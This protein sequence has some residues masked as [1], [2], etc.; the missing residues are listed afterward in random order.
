MTVPDRDAYARHRAEEM[1]HYYGGLVRT[2]LI[3]SAVIFI[4]GFPVVGPTLPFGAPLAVAYALMLFLVA[5]LTN[6]KSL[7]SLMAGAIIAGLGVALFE[8]AALMEYD[9]EGLPLFLVRQLVASML[10]VAFYFSLKSIRAILLRSIG[11]RTF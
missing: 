11:R 8:T 5:G 9:S 10:L 1:A 2:L 7:D 4:L 6:P 3:L